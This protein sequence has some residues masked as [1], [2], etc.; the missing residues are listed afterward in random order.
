MNN[1]LILYTIIDDPRVVKI[2]D[3]IIL[4]CRYI[5]VLIHILY[6]LTRAYACMSICACICMDVWVCT[7]LHVYV[8]IRAEFFVIQN[9]IY[10]YI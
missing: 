1:T 2:I 7:G 4:H 9:I 8:Y 5:G 10:I 3:K 6:V